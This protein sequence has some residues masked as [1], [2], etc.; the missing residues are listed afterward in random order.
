MSDVSGVEEGDRTLQFGA[1]LVQ[2]TTGSGLKV[3]EVG[4]VLRACPDPLTVFRVEVA[5]PERVVSQELDHEGFEELVVLGGGAEE[6]GTNERQ[7][8]LC[9]HGWS[10]SGR[11]SGSLREESSPGGRGRLNP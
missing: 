5:A 8:G 4:F 3:E 1:E 9:G 6:E 2:L 10:S 11:R 7:V